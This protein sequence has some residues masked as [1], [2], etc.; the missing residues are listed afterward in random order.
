MHF[1]KTERSLPHSQ[2]AATCL[3]PEPD[4]FCPCPPTHFLNIHF[5]ITSHLRLCLPSGLF[6]SGLPTKTLCTPLLYPIPAACP[7]HLILLYLV[8]RDIFGECRSQ[9]SSLL[10]PLQYPVT[11]S[12]LGSNIV[13]ITLFSDTL[14]LCSSLKVSDH[15]SHP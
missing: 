12:L 13:P 2:E 9:S 1:M 3:Y 11:S 14:S 4:Q 6:P 5:N 10:T 15:V 7:V 8:T